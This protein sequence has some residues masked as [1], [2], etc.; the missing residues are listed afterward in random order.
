MLNLICTALYV[1]SVSVIWCYI[2]ALNKIPLQNDQEVPQKSK[3]LWVTG[4]T[5][6]VFP[7]DC[8][9]MK[10]VCQTQNLISIFNHKYL[11][12]Q[13][14]DRLVKVM[15]FLTELKVYNYHCS[16]SKITEFLKGSKT[17]SQDPFKDSLRERG[18]GRGGDWLQPH[19]PR[20]QTSVNANDRWQIYNFIL[21]VYD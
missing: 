21:N 6:L 17:K 1:L 15:E 18:W 16:M 10:T 19:T 5:I 20:M 3:N 11:D 14:G 13:T 7:I 4:F 9:V 2:E 8:T 12:N